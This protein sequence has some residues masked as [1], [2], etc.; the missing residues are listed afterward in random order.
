MQDGDAVVIF[1]FRSDRVVELS[2]ALEYHDFTAFDRCAHK[3]CLR[4]SICSASDTGFLLACVHAL[5]HEQPR[6]GCAHS[7]AVK[8][9][10][11]GPQL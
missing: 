8:L 4:F 6:K 10:P 1:N 2:K 11:I 9:Q 5:P 7:T 3:L